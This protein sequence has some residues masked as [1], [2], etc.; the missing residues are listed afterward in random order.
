MDECQ[1]TAYS[2]S[3]TT[4][5]LRDVW[6]TSS[7][8]VKPNLSDYYIVD[9]MVGSKVGGFDTFGTFSS[10]KN[11]LEPNKPFDISGRNADRKMLEGESIVIK[12]RR[13]GSPTPVANAYTVQLKIGATGG[14][15][16]FERPLLD[17]FTMDVLANPADEAARKAKRD[18]LARGVSGEQIISI[19][20]QDKGGRY[21]EIDSSTN[22][23]SK[24]QLGR[25]T[26]SASTVLYGNGTWGP[27]DLWTYVKLGSTFTTTSSTMVN[28]TGLSFTPAVSKDYL[29]EAQVLLESGTANNSAKIGLTWPSTLT[30]GAGHFFSGLAGSTIGT[31]SISY[32]GN[33]AGTSLTNT[34]TVWSGTANVPYL[35][36]GFF[37]MRTG[38]STSGDFQVTLSSETAGTTVRAKQGSFLRYRTI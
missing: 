2:V 34:T 14:T 11:S 22:L 10:R 21:V 8:E 3:R 12:V 24:S 31:A 5:V 7:Y 1:I 36:T 35:T 19:P 9:V 17:S 13:Y 18:S 20:L 32:I 23:A 15:S 26:A 25:G 27:V 6:I 37:L 29:I 38:A 33:T 28:V 30:D 4:E 16:Q